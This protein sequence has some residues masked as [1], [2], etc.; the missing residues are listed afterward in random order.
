MKTTIEIRDKKIE[1]E[2][3]L[4]TFQI[5]ENTFKHNLLGDID[6][7]ENNRQKDDDDK[8][9]TVNTLF[10]MRNIIWALAATADSKVK[11]DDLKRFD[12]SEI[13]LGYSIASALVV[14]SFQ[15]SPKNVSAAET[16][17]VNDQI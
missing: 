17:V 7:I 8:E 15:V 9:R 3:C 10:D 5:Y 6:K 16:E 2:S 11:L 14:K 1:L 4:E 12:P 13:I